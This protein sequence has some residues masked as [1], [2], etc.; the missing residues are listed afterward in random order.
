MINIVKLYL[1]NKNKFK[2][3]HFLHSK[4]IFCNLKSKVTYLVEST[5]IIMFSLSFFPFFILKNGSELLIS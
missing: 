3:F 5:S 4:V 2:N 1:F